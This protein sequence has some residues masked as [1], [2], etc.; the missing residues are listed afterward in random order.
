[1]IDQIGDD[2]PGDDEKKEGGAQRR[3]NHGHKGGVFRQGTHLPTGRNDHHEGARVGKE[4][5]DPK[6]PEIPF[7]EQREAGADGFLAHRIG[8]KDG[9]VAPLCGPLGLPPEAPVSFTFM[10]MVAR[11]PRGM[12]F[13][14]EKSSQTWDLHSL[15]AGNLLMG[16]TYV[17]NQE[18]TLIILRIAP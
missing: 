9:P 10:F 14:S 11:S 2:S 8:M 13:P 18:S 4:V 17:R 16:I 12:D 6:V 3:L 15:T 5:A 7:P 1:M